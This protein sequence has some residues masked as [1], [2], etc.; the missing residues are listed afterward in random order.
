AAAVV[1]GECEQGILICGTGIGMSIA[2]NKVPGIRA[3]LCNEIFSAKMA[4]NHND[5]NILCIG[6]RVV[7]PG[8]AQEIVKAYFTSGFEGGRHARR[9]EKLNLLDARK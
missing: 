2:A 9:V 5:A 1:S 3:A 7:G 6:A 8:V 4:R